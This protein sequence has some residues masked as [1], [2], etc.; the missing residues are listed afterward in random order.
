[1]RIWQQ[2]RLVF[3]V[4]ERICDLLAKNG[5]SRSDLAEAL[6]K[7]PSHVTQ[8]LNGD[9]NMT[10]HTVA[11]LFWAC[12]RATHITDEPIEVS[13]IS[14]VVFYVDADWY[15]AGQAVCN[16]ESRFDRSMTLGLSQSTAVSP[17]VEAIE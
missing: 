3:E 2:E 9:A 14:P 11:D 15:Q 8:L 13:A 7:A 10:L 16:I 6:G 17:S 12:R 4:T 1:M 5:M